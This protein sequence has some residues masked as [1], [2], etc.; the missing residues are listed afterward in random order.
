MES[1][2]REYDGYLEVNLSKAQVQAIRSFSECGAPSVEIS[3]SAIVV[4]YKGRDTERIMVNRLV[5]LAK[6]IGDAEG[7]IIF[8]EDIEEGDNRFE[9]FSIRGGKLYRQKGRIVRSEEK[10]LS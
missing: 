8:E 10:L 9:F 4:S 5:E 1:E 3:P 6:I 7:E 2:L